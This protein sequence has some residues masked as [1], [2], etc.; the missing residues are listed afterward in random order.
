MSMS[1]TGR[2]TNKTPDAAESNAGDDFHIAW[3]VRKALELLNFEA[4]GIKKI[5]LEGVTE[6]DAAQL[7][8]EDDSLLGVDLTEYFGGEDY[9]SAT[10]IVF[11]QLKYSSRHPQLEWTAAKICQGKKKGSAGSIIDRLSRF[12]GGIYTSYGREEVLKKTTIKLVSNRPAAGVLLS[13]F[14][15]VHSVLQ[16][17]P[18]LQAFKV[19]TKGLSPEEQ[20]ALQ[21]IWKAS[22]LNENEITDFFRV[23]DFSECN[24]GARFEQRKHAMQVIS[25]LGGSM[26]QKEYDVLRGAVWDKMMPDPG[27]SHDLTVSDILYPFQCSSLEDLFPVQNSFEQT[28]QLIERTQQGEI[29]TVIASQPEKLICIHGGAGIGK[30]TV[31]KNIAGH[32]SDD[33]IVVLFDC[34]GSGSFLAPEDKRHRHYNA[35][36]QLINEVALQAGTPFLL[37][38]DGQDDLYIKELKKR[39]ELAAKALEAISADKKIILIID[40]ADNAVIA[41]E[42]DSSRCFVHDLVN[43]NLPACCRLIVTTRT[44]RKEKLKL[45]DDCTD[46]LLRPFD[47]TE[48]GQFL[49]IRHGNTS[50]KQIKEFRQLTQGIPRVM[51]YVLDLP[52]PTLEEK[53]KP[54]KPGGKSLDDIFKLRIRYAASKTG[55]KTR[56]KKFLISLIAL[57]RPIPVAYMA[58][59]SGIA[60][61]ALEDYPVDL[62]HGIRFEHNQFSIRDEDFE[63]FLRTHYIPS[64]SDLIKVADLF[65]ENALKD[66]YASIH[67]GSALFKAGKKAVLH[68]VVIE[69]KLLDYPKDA[70]KNREVFVDRTRL[71]MLLAKD[72]GNN[73]NFLK[74]LGVA[75]E[76]AK[77]NKLLEEILLNKAELAVSY[78]NLETIQKMYFQQGNPEWFGPV[79]FRSAAIFSRKSATHDV[80]KQHLNRA[81]KWIQYRNKLT[82]DELNQYQISVSDIAYGAEA[83]LRIFGV[84]ECIRWINGWISKQLRYGIVKQL[85]PVLLEHATTAQINDWVKGKVFRVDIALLIVQ[86]FFNRGLS[87]PID[88]Q[89]VF[90]SIPLLQRAKRKLQPAIRNSAIAFCEYAAMKKHDHTTYQPLLDLWDR[91]I[92]EHIPSF[93]DHDLPSLRY[94]KRDIDFK[95][96]KAALIAHSSNELLQVIDFLPQSVKEIADL[97]YEEKSRRDQR[98]R[99]FHQLYRHLLPLYQLRIKY[100]L[101]TGKKKAVKKDLK[102]IVDGIDKDYDFYHRHR[103]D[104]PY[105]Y[106]FIALRLIDIQLWNND[107]EILSIIKKGFTIEKQVYLNLPLSLAES[108]SANRKFHPEVLQLLQETDERL[109]GNIINGQEKTNYYT[110]AATIGS[111]VSEET[112]KYYFDKMVACAE[113]I[114]F[115]AHDQII[116]LDRITSRELTFQSPRLAYEAARFI[117]YCHEHLSGD[118]NFPWM[119]G[120]NAI[121]KLDL[122]SA[123]PI[124]CRWDHRGIQEISDHFE[125]LLRKSI[126]EQFILPGE[127]G[128]LLRSYPYYG[129]GLSETVQQI[130]QCYDVNR[131]KTGKNLFVENFF[132]DLKVNFGKG[133]Y[134]EVLKKLDEIISNARYIRQEMKDQFRAFYKKIVSLKGYVEKNE[135]QSMRRTKSND[136]SKQYQSLARKTDITSPV[137]IDQYFEGLKKLNPNGWVDDETA[138]LVL[139]KKVKP[140]NHTGFLDAVIDLHEDSLDFYSFRTFFKQQLRHWDMYPEVK[141]WKKQ[142]FKKIVRAKLGDLT[143][144][145]RFDLFS[146]KTIAEICNVTPKELAKVTIEIIPDYLE[147]MPSTVLYQLYDLLIVDVS[148]EDKQY[149]LQWL[150]GRWNAAIPE[151]FGDGKFNKSLTPP[152]GSSDVIA[153]FLRYQLGHPDKRLRWRVCHSL[154]RF[155]LLGEL[156]VFEALLRRQNEEF[157]FA[158]QHH[159]HHYF[160]MSAKLYLWIS[161]DRIC[162]EQP[163]AMIAMKKYFIA[164]LRTSTLVHAQIIYFV[165]TAC[166][167]LRQF[168]VRVFSAAEQVLIDECLNNTITGRPRKLKRSN[169]T[170]GFRDLQTKFRFDTTDT[171]PYWYAPLGRVFGL[172][173]NT[174]A[175]LADKYII[176]DWGYTG[177]PWDDNHVKPAERD[178]YLTRNDHGSEPTIENLQNYFEYHAMFC[179]A[180]ELLHTRPQKAEDAYYDNWNYWIRS[181][182]LYDEGSWLADLRDPLPNIEKLWRGGR[183]ETNWEWSIQ[184]KDFDQTIGLSDPYYPEY[185]VISSSTTIHYGEDY[186]TAHV[187]SALVQTA[188]GPALLRALQTN[189]RYDNNLPLEQEERGADEEYENGIQQPDDPFSLEGWI[190]HVGSDYEGIDDTDAA[191]GRIE[192]NRLV[193]GKKIL[194]DK[195]LNY[196]PDFRTSYLP[197]EEEPV[198]RLEVWNN[199]PRTISYGDMVSGGSRLLLRKDILL[200]FLTNISRCLIIKCELYRRPERRRG[201]Q[202]DLSYY[203]LIYLIYPDGKIETITGDSRLG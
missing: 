108:L 1:T 83:I 62:W 73:L 30:S 124:L 111:R 35:I 6:K 156:A 79:H 186:E 50:E 151:D 105:I 101:T 122:R 159:E 40:A 176:D 153:L 64:H 114:D 169:S 17:L 51:A 110:R 147:D 198:S 188:K 125:V 194:E 92:P 163:A 8:R 142:N 78:G 166:L 201:Y 203:T 182:G 55:D 129:E 60:L 25:S 136:L 20:D 113:A 143:E 80:A 179:V 154:R 187:D 103:G 193:L 192:K 117:E 149:L 57:P 46:I 172:S 41:A 33:H 31:A 74:L 44:E 86:T 45:P 13:A 196:T 29:N 28:T 138:L 139:V 160:W 155:A 54:L 191:Y 116:C 132:H 85:L 96:R 3:T 4:E 140:G 184:R 120:F 128:A 23:L 123:F 106:R 181:W 59:V 89:Q 37:L 82:D 165:R 11:S 48:A 53:L 22:G 100:L 167:K 67:V 2:T 170:T 88:L 39:L 190:R 5:T 178:Y 36:L 199:I 109:E 195:K 174:I 70:V 118:D 145:G 71:A 189:T 158:F 115:S 162:A 61:S 52:M 9:Q 97:E 200:S 38:R 99:E 7:E 47:I 112:G 157:N 56:L 12:F 24:A 137:S 43:M 152:E 104:L 171:V 87:A 76:A 65:L 148:K 141:K 93:Y 81:E 98:R 66:E 180:M 150:L 146:Y 21:R 185:L 119:H 94:E 90:S 134:I 133:H 121:L 131:D 91:S 32:F 161:I 19:V 68:D 15:K 69:R 14:T 10:R 49:A 84:D 127:A 16:S 34:Y 202:Q 164:E 197:G 168:D 135:E 126:E 173:Q 42:N 107:R 77:T 27:I 130:L 63:T 177:D 102:K 95:F 175:E 183:D 75:A 26:A 58:S 72:S 144:H 18:A